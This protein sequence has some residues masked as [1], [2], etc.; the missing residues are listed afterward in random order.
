MNEDLIT[1]ESSATNGSKRVKERSAAYPAISID[2]AVRFVSEV[3]K[4]FRNTPAKRDDILA[5]IESADTRYI[6]ASAY[7][8]LLSREKD[9][10]QVTP[11][12]KSISS[13]LSET[14]KRVA[15]LQAFESP[16][17]NKELIDKFD[18]DIIPKELT[19]HLSRF[20]RITE[21]AAPLASEIFITNAKICDVI[22]SQNRLVFQKTFDRLKSGGVSY[23]E[24]TTEENN[25]TENVQPQQIFE[26]V[27]P[28]NIKPN[29]L[30]QPIH[31]QLLLDEG[32][33]DEKLKIR[34]TEGKIAYLHYPI[35][36]T[37]KDIGIIRK[38]LDVLEEVAE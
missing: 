30:Q 16:K 6:A 25:F 4:N 18:G 1:N 33:N 36:I 19:I 8:S 7:Y 35:S 17:F 11:I 29:I 20:H 32:T 24:V 34:L 23:A 14:E 26:N 13:P 5:I 2:E 15:L 10:Y 37:K 12:Y 22:D 3:Y 21:D 27:Q 28:V 9:F 31:Q 38:Q